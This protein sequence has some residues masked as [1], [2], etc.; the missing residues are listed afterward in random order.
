MTRLGIL[1]DDIDI[2]K[3]SLSKSKFVVAKGIYSQLSSAD[4]DNQSHTDI[5]RNKFIEISD[6]FCSKFDTIKFKSLINIDHKNNCF[7]ATNQ[8]LL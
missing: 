7:K 6:S 5:Q 8:G 4:E 1:S 3:D 2:I